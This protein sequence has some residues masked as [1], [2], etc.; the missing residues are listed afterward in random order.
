MIRVLGTGEA[1]EW[2][3]VVRGSAQHDFYFLPG[4]HALAERL[5]GGTGRLFVYERDG[6]TLALPLMLRPVA[7]VE[8][9]SGMAGR[10]D[11]TSVY[12]YAGPVAS[13][14]AMPESVLRGF[15]EEIASALKEAGVVS[16]FSRLHPLLSQCELLAGLGEC[17]RLGQTVSIDLTAP[18]AEQWRQHSGT[19]KSRINR[20]RRSGAIGS[21]DGEKRQLSEFV[22]IYHDT[23]ARVGASVTSLGGTT[24]KS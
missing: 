18:A 1:G 2:S 24:L 14:A 22:E 13:H 11:A 21:R 12:G 5:G 19:M 20:L 9:L 4:Y 15:R 3:S 6:H 17:R 10:Y 8:G 7:E 23:M 16:V